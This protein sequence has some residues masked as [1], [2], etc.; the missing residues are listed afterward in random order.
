MKKIPLMTPEAHQ[1]FE[2]LKQQIIQEPV[3]I[4]PRSSF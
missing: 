1:A 4:P 2:M 3:L